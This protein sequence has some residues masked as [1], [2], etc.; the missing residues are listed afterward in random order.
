[1]ILNSHRQVLL[2]TGREEIFQ[3]GKRET[4]F[5]LQVRNGGEELLLDTLVVNINVNYAF[6]F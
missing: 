3:L 6:R 2:T 4:R 1:M 5:I